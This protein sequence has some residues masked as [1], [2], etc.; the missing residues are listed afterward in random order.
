MRLT[1]RQWI[2]A[3]ALL[4]AALGGACGAWPLIEPLDAGGDYRIP[5]SLGQDYWLF[6][7]ACRAA[8]PA[9]RVA[10]IGDSVVWGHYVAAGETLTH[11]LNRMDGSDRFANL[12]VDGAHPAALAGLLRHYGGALRGGRALVLFNPLWISSPRQDLQGKKEMSF[13]H[14]DLVPQFFPRIPCY[15]RPV[16]RRI[17]VVLTR[18]LP[19]FQWADH[20]RQAYFGNKDLGS[21]A[22]ERPRGNPLAAIT[23]RLP[24]PDEQPDPKPDARPWSEK[25]LA[26]APAW[27]ELESS[28][29][30][31]S[32]LAA[33][34]TLRRRGNDVFV[35]IN[36]MN[37]HMM[38]EDARRLYRARRDEMSVLLG[39]CGYP[40]HV[41]PPLPAGLYADTSHP[42]AEGYAL[43]AKSL[44]EDASF[45]VFCRNANR[46]GNTP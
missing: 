15:R 41:P 42:L 4:A 8:E 45:Q 34:D 24:P 5:Y 37:E 22:C 32:F 17:S 30:W 2:A 6:R 35:V 40:V 46:K 43:I 10:A 14:P 28:F 44:Y 29:Q 26:F 31:R 23:L 3:V 20:L 19:L 11:Y 1:P 27:V 7:R 39:R 25:D 21:W 16:S 36:P 9:R 18:R 33:L 13:N 38:D 12:A